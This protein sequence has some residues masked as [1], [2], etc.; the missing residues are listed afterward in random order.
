[1]S[2]KIKVNVRNFIQADTYMNF[3]RMKS[4]EEVSGGIS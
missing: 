4:P 2:E 3:D 1:M